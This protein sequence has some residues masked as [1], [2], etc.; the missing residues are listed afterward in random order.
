MKHP[1]E[2]NAALVKAKTLR[3]QLFLPEGLV[4]W[5]PF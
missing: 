5:V 3:F 4:I 2:I 1:E